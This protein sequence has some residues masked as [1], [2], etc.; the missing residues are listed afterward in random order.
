REC[1]CNWLK[2]VGFLKVENVMNYTVETTEQ[3]TS[4][5]SPYESL[6]NFLM[7]DD[8]SKTIEGYPAPERSV[9]LCTK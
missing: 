7:P 5:D 2:R 3:R 8:A 9:M 1:L 4:K 6:E